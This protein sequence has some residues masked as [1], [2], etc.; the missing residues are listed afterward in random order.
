MKDK[1]MILNVFQL[2]GLLDPFFEVENKRL[3]IE[4]AKLFNEF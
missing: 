1:G 2:L 3:K 4:I